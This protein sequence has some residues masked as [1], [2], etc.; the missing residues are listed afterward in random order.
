MFEN[1][2]EN[3]QHALEKLR[4]QV[5]VSEEVL[6]E[7]LR[8]IRLALPG[9]ERR[10]AS[11]EAPENRAFNLRNPAWGPVLVSYVTQTPHARYPRLGQFYTGWPMPG[12]VRCRS[13]R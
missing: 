9:G 4:G 5:R 2:S 12:V 7:T 1:L 3:L 6:T 8:E 13:Q 11:R 10:R